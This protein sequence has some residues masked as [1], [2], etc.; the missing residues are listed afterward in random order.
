MSAVQKPHSVPEARRRLSGRLHY[1]ANHGVRDSAQ[2]DLGIICARLDNLEEQ[3]ETLR[4]CVEWFAS[5]DAWT[6]TPQYQAD[7][8]YRFNTTRDSMYATPWGFA[9]DALSKVSS[10]AKRPT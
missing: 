9:K 8:R 10:P 1:I 7:G 6:V 3:L 4:E 5:D 2:K